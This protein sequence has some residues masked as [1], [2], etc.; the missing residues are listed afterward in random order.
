MIANS[1]DVSYSILGIINQLKLPRNKNIEIYIIV[2]LWH[3]EKT[4]EL[5]IHDLFQNVVIYKNVRRDLKV[6]LT[7]IVAYIYFLL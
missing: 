3:H 2:Y 1:N 6:F 4:E 7:K 5:I